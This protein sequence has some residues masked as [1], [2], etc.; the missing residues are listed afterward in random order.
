MFYEEVYKAPIMISQILGKI[1]HNTF[2]FTYYKLASQTLV[3]FKLG[4][5]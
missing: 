3:S 1:T 4:D 5:L 2:S